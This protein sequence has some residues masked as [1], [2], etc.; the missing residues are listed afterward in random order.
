MPNKKRI[1]FVTDR[2]GHLHDA[3]RLVGQMELQPDVLV[4]TEGPDV[5]SL[6]KSPALAATTIACVP[7]AFFWIGKKRLWSPFRFLKVVVFSFFYVLKYRPQVVIST[8]ASNVVFVCLFAKLFGATLVHIENLAQVVNASITG[9]I[10]Y[11][12][13]DHFFVQWEELL[14]CYGPKARY[15]G[16]VI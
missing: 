10:L 2:G 4:T 12:F 1:L 6:K 8:G 13:A 7:Q 14:K 3:L 5:D 16:W 9:R 11:P 15:E